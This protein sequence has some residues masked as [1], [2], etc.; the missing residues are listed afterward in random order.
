MK[1]ISNSVRSLIVYLI[2]MILM[3]SC[4]ASA[5][6]QTSEK[7][8]YRVVP[9][10][11][12]Q[13]YPPD[14]FVIEVNAEH[15]T[16]VEEIHAKNRHASFRGHIA[17]GSVEYNKDYSKVQNRV[18]NWHVASVFEIWD[19][20]DTAT[21][22][23]PTPNSHSTATEIAE[24]P[25]E[26]I[27]KNGTVYAPAI[28]RISDQIDPNSRTALANVS[29][30]GMTGAGEK[31][32]I[33]GLIIK[34][35]EPRNVVVRALGPSLSAAGVQQVAG[36]PKIEVFSASGRRITQNA[37]WKTDPR[38]AT[39]SEAYP[40]LAPPNEKEAALL[41]TL[42]PGSYTLHGTNEDGTEGVVLLEAYDVDSNNE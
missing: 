24:N 10:Y 29:N 38:S 39:L 3:L 7:F 33:T 37:D 18:W 14:S 34:G 31:A 8:Y 21:G 41:L 30:R 20:N 35:G 13:G 9:L 26:W 1:T 2:G 11:L 5:Q 17:S 40:D 19:L 32:L 42:M 27:R 25:D 4:A 23:L 22:G 16:Q 12:K 28:Y 15:K 6:A 36:N